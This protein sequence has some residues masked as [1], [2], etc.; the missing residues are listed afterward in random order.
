MQAVVVVMISTLHQSLDITTKS[1]QT[2]VEKT[3]AARKDKDN[4]TKNYEAIFC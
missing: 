2:F 4:K 1:A 3:A